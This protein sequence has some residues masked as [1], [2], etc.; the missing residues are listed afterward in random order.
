MTEGTEL[1]AKSAGAVVG[2]LA[3]DS[4]ALGPVR[5]YANY[6]SA[7]VHMRH[8]PA[9]AKRAMA[10]AEKIRASGL[11]RHAWEELDEPL[12]T[13][14]LEGM[15]QETDPDLSRVWENLLAN[16]LTHG[17][18]NVRRVFPTIL[19]ASNRKRFWDAVVVDGVYGETFGQ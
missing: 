10:T 11:P 15:A 3:D 1:V 7:R 14:I 12:V 9:L 8:L 18:P 6:L 4:N 2:A 5:E 13:A 16:E 17:S 19:R